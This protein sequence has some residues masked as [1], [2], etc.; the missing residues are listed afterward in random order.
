[1]FRD[2]LVFSFSVL[3]LPLSVWFGL[4][5]SGRLLG[6]KGAHV[7]ATLLNLL[8]FLLSIYVFNAYTLSGNFSYLVL[9]SW[10]RCGDLFVDWG[11]MFDS[12]TLSMFVV[13]TLVSTCVHFYSTNYMLGDPGFVRF[14]SYI[15][16]FTFFMLFLVASDNFV[17]MLVGWEGVGIC[18]YLLVSFWFTRVQ[19]VKAALKALI[20]NRVGDCGFVIAILLIFKV[21]RSVNF[22]VL[23]VITPYLD[24]HKT[25]LSVGLY[26]FEFRSL[27][28]CAFFLLFGVFGKSAQIGLHC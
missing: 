17:Q 2:G 25:V 18:S 6:W 4:S 19:A 20:Y 9:G 10:F 14:M 8:S 27:N 21:C 13:V 5:I 7:V 24:A 26:V 22:D 28:L 23:Y 15:S 12:L 11:F 16:L 1:M 3:F